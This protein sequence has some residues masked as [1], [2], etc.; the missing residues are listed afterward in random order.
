M[1]LYLPQVKTCAGKAEG[2]RDIFHRASKKNS[3]NQKK[4]LRIKKK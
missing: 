3:Q 2:R 1:A 4:I